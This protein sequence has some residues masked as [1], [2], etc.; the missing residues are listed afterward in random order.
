MFPRNI[1]LVTHFS[2]IVNYVRFGSITE[3]GYGCGYGAF[4]Y[5]RG[6]TGLASLWLC[7][8]KGLIFYF[9]LELFLLIAF[10]FMYR[11]DKSL[12]FLQ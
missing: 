3:F 7:P 2:W 11:H 10:K 6:W 9:P 12:V 5:N 8:G 1:R 4:S